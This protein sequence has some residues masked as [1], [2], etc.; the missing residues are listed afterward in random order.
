MFLQRAIITASF[1]SLIISA[2]ALAQGRGQFEETY[3]GSTRSEYQSGAGIE[4]GVLATL[5]IRQG[6]YIESVILTV[7]SA[8]GNGRVEVLIDGRVIA[9]FA[10]S[11]VLRA[12][13]VSIRGEVGR[14]IGSLRLKTYGNVHIAHYAVTLNEEYSNGPGRPGRPGDGPGRP[15][16]PGDGPGRPGTPPPAPIRVIDA[17]EFNSLLLDLRQTAHD[18]NKES[19]VGNYVRYWVNKQMTMEQVAQVLAHFTHDSGKINA[20]RTMRTILI[21]DIAQMQQILSKFTHDSSKQQARQIIMQG[22]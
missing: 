9:N 15:G 3:V 6:A 4:L 11:Q 16:R 19:L 8:Q 1:L 2:D 13:Q 14:H 18:S 12:E 10:A 20:L 5:G 22:V 17:A 7:A 21:V